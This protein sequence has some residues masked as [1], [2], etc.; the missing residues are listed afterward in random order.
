M[1]NTY[2]YKFEVITAHYGQGFDV[3][4]IAGTSDLSDG[5]APF[6][7]IPNGLNI[8]YYVCICMYVC[9][10]IYSARVVTKG[11]DVLIIAGKLHS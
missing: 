3:L 5:H 6:I 10:Y 2:F 9:A 11:F 1:V 8:Y 4:I 7:L